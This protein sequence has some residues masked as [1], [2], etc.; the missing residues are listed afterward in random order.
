MREALAHVDMIRER[1]GRGEAL[2]E[3]DFDLERVYGT[4]T[5]LVRQFDVRYDPGTPVPCDDA[6]ADR[7]FAAAMEFFVACGVFHREL[8]R[9]ATFSR[10]EVE[11]VVTGFQDGAWFGEGMDRRRIAARRPDDSSRP[12][13]HVGSGTVASSEEIAR[14]IVFG[15]ASIAEADSMSVNALNRLDGVPVRPGE[16]SEVEAA[17]RSIA[18]ARNAC[19]AAG[20]P[21][22]AIT[23]GIAAAGS[24]RTTIAAACDP[25][26]G[27]RPSDAII[28]GALP[29][30]KVSVDMME[31]ATFC[32]RSGCRLVLAGAPLIGGF[33][34]GPAGAAVLNAAYALFGM[35]VYPADYFLS[36]PLEMRTN[37]GTGR[38]AIWAMALSA[39]AVSRNT[40]MP[41]VALAY[42]AG[43]PWTESFF[44]ESA[45]FLAAAVASG[46]SFQSPH[47]A[48]ALWEDHVTPLEMRLT[49]AM[50][51]ACAG[52][53]RREANAIVRRLLP[54]YEKGLPSAPPGRPYAVCFDPSRGVPRE[55]Y[56]DFVGGV[57]SVLR[58]LGVSAENWRSLHSRS[59][60]R[61]ATRGEETAPEHPDAA[62]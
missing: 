18:V 49:T 59:G 28:V 29:E 6:L 61:G 25:A 55:E 41:I 27:W 7:V 5:R 34:G 38:E 56:E 15:N 1:A 31:K 48:R 43:G 46:A 39:Q 57:T 62:A 52:L 9:V 47:P 13:C 32:R 2:E 19:A 33:C 17:V 21:G 53:D 20:R 23:N 12:W 44:Y 40:R 16:F 24:A 10:E 14:Q 51:L 36:L 37:C 11:G 50:G 60:E 45:A 3:Q 30:F 35:L 26:S 8:R 54:R 22:L 4:L 58:S 42:A